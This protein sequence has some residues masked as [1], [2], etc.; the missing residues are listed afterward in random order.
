MLFTNAGAVDYV[1]NQKTTP[2]F[3]ADGMPYFPIF[4]GKDAKFGNT[5]ALPCVETVVNGKIT[6][7]KD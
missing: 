6:E 1:P 4:A 5:K 3:K 2:A 7:Q